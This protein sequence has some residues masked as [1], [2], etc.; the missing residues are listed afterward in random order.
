MAA[1][2]LLAAV[3][4]ECMGAAAPA[5]AVGEGAGALLAAT[6]TCDTGATTLGEVTDVSSP[7]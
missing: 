2:V 3:R 5:G 6:C 1:N 4:T 7:I